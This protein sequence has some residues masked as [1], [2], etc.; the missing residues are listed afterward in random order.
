MNSSKKPVKNDFKH[1]KEKT[2][3]LHYLWREYPNGNRK[4]SFGVGNC[5]HESLHIQNVPLLKTQCCV[6]YE[7]MKLHLLPIQDNFVVLAI[8]YLNY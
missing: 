1:H 4:R 8:F 7:K 5:E 2:N 6:K 3:F